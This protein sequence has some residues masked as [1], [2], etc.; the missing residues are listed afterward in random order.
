MHS[1]QP[2][3]MSVSV[4]VWDVITV[5]VEAAAVLDQ[6]DLEELGQRVEPV[7][8]GAH[9]DGGACPNNWTKIVDLVI[10]RLEPRSYSPLSPG[11]T[12]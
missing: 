4:R 1:I 8:E 7:G 2:V 11:L 10:F 3:A 5:R 9:R 12:R 6:V